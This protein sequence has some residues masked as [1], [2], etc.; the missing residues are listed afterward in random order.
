MLKLTERIILI[1]DPHKI[2]HNSF[3]LAFV[4]SVWYRNEIYFLDFIDV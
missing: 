3:G 1:T 4:N 2:K